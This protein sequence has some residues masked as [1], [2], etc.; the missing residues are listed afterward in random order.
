[1]LLQVLDFIQILMI[2]LSVCV[3]WFYSCSSQVYRS[4]EFKSET[5][6]FT[7]KTKKSILLRINDDKFLKNL[8]YIDYI[9]IS[10][11]TF[12]FLLR[13]LVSPSK[14]DFMKKFDNIV[15]FVST[16]FAYIDFIFINCN[17][18]K[19]EVIR[20]VRLLRLF[21]LN[22]GLKI[23]I[24][25]LKASAFILNLILIVIIIISIIFGSLVYYLEKL[26]IINQEKNKFSSII[27]GLWY[28]V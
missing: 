23:I 15:D 7:T 11:F 21:S 10:W 6:D 17:L 26:T 12:D 28:T 3:L 5:V 27:D 13:F 16:F 18:R 9:T 20:V 4:I 19:L 14:I 2:I 22:P 1:M 8:K 25:S 24:A